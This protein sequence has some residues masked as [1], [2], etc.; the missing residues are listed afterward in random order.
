MN[1]TKIKKEQFLTFFT[2]PK[3]SEKGESDRI[4]SIM[5]VTFAL[6]GLP[7]PM[8]AHLE[9][10]FHEKKAGLKLESNDISNQKDFLKMFN[11]SYIKK[12]QKKI[13]NAGYCMSMY[14]GMPIDDIYTIML[15]M[16]ESY[17]SFLKA[18]NLKSID[19]PLL[20]YAE[21]INKSY[22]YKE[23]P[24]EL[25]AFVHTPY[26]DFKILNT[27][28]RNVFTAKAEKMTFG[29]GKKPYKNA[30]DAYDFLQKTFNDKIII[31]S[32]EIKHKEVVFNDSKM[33]K[34]FASHMSKDITKE[35]IQSLPNGLFTRSKRIVPLTDDGQKS[36][37]KIIRLG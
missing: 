37:G 29:W 35:D 32:G 1:T 11:I 12:D 4:S 21:A 6:N 27:N 34:L 23:A 9:V 13:I 17:E 31:E 19:C 10:K 20:S 16:K 25:L 2:K 24:K 22:S 36:N 26:P 7:S 33:T 18:K 14:M 8:E 3:I 15:N 5:S 30:E 28:V